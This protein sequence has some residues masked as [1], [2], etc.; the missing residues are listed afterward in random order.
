MIRVIIPYHLRSL[1]QLEGE[2]E[3]DLP[4]PVTIGAVIDH[5][6]SQYPVLKGTIRDHITGQRRP[7][8]R[9]FACKEDLSDAAPETILPETVRAGQDPFMIIGAMAGGS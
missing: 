2:L 1:A 4:A 8:V 5:L 9:F 6:E 7:F 3:L